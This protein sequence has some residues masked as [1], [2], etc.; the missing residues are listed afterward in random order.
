[1]SDANSWLNYW[2]V[3]GRTNH[4]LLFDRD[5]RPKPAFDAVVRLAQQRQA[6][7]ETGPRARE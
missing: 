5:H 1:V 2:P 6:A 7:R 4:P 3:R